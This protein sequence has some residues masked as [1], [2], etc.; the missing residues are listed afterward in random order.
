MP[1]SKSAHSDHA[2]DSSPSRR[3]FSPDLKA[4]ESGENYPTYSLSYSRQQ[5]HQ[6]SYVNLLTKKD[7]IIGS[8]HHRRVTSVPL[9]HFAG[10]DDGRGMDLS[11]ETLSYPP[12]I[13]P[14]PKE[15]AEAT[16]WQKV[17]SQT[18][19]LCRRTHA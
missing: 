10:K 8:H 4:A 11:Q 6:L 19:I 15:P 12:K 17:R 14:L 2:K 13:V 18:L 16:V 7:T 9:S 1:R 3:S 5:N